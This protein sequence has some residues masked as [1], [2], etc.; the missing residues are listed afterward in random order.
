MLI[1]GTEPGT[2]ARLAYH[3]TRLLTNNGN[4]ATLGFG[5]ALL[6][7]VLAWGT[8]WIFR[9]PVWYYPV[10]WVLILTGLLTADSVIGI[11]NTLMELKVLDSLGDHYDHRCETCEEE[12]EQGE[13]PG[14]EGTPVA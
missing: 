5:G 13:G 11:R 12:G 6:T 4:R 9:F 3:N 1:K 2:F 8:V 14:V 7:T 10:A